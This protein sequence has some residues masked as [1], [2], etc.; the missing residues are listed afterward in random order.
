MT[1][2]GGREILWEQLRAAQ[3]WLETCKAACH[4]ACSL[5]RVLQEQFASRPRSRLKN[6]EMKLLRKLRLMS[7]CLPSESRRKLHRHRDEIW[8]SCGH[9]DLPP[10]CRRLSPLSPSRSSWRWG[11]WLR[12]Q[13]SAGE[14]TDGPGI[15]Q[16]ATHMW[17]FA[18]HR[19][20]SKFSCA[21]WSLDRQLHAH[22]PSFPR[23]LLLAGLTACRHSLR[24]ILFG[25]FLSVCPDPGYCTFKNKKEEE[26]KNFSSHCWQLTDKPLK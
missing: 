25:V 1:Q 7:E 21:N 8:P 26:E 15:S 23:R 13:N 9:P 3:A 22:P 14:A 17:T 5:L 2:K 24:L 20:E 10:G 18:A 6:V 11:C 16:L 12:L 4:F 19:H